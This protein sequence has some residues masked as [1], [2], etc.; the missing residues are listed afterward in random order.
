LLPGGAAL[1]VVAIGFGG[2]FG[3]TARYRHSW[4]LLTALTRFWNED[5]GLSILLA[6]LVVTIFVLPPL[7]PPGSGRS[8]WGDLLFV[9]LLIAGVRALFVWRVARWVLMP[10]A[11]IA[12]TVV[13][14]SWVAPV[15]HPWDRLAAL[16]SLLLL[17]VIVVGQAFRSGPITVH[18]VMGGVAAYLFLGLI[19]AEAYALVEMLNPGAFVGPV[20][21]AD[22][23][24]SWICFGFVPLSTVGY[25]DVLPVHPLARSLASLESVTGP[26]FLTVLL[27][28]LVALGAPGRRDEGSE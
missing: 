15:P 12:I 5:R 24:R 19:W 13:F 6:L 2:R 10:V 25:G 20:D 27:A 8:A 23:P 9:L 22:G 18:R 26:L 17:L 14:A 28:R 1:V 11:A 7:V 3:V 21:V 4:P 16:L